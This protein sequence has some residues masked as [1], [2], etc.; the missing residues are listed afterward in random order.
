MT[1]AET[2]SAYLTAVGFLP[3]TVLAS[4]LGPAELAHATFAGVVTSVGL[5]FWLM[6][7]EW[8]GGRVWKARE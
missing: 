2:W 3:L 8:I 7:E 1:S 4:Y 6:F 5:M